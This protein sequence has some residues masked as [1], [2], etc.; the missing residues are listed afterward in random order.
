DILAPT[1]D[2][3]RL[4]LHLAEVVGEH[5][6]RNRPVRDAL[7]DVARK[8][9]IVADAGG[10]HEARIGREPVDPLVAVTLEHLR[11]VGAVGESLDGKRGQIGFHRYLSSRAN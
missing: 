4:A 9:L 6:E 5:F 1:R 7:E 2:L 11:L 3:E 10:P 8:R